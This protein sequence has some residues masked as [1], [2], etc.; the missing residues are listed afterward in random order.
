MKSGVYNKPAL[1]SAGAKRR[2]PMS[3][4]KAQSSNGASANGSYD[5]GASPSSVNGNGTMKKKITLYVDKDVWKEFQKLAIDE[6]K[7]YSEMAETAFTEL[8][9]SL[10]QK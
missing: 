7:E 6:E 9:T 2:A 1:H 4:R 10:R 8:T 5:N 3:A